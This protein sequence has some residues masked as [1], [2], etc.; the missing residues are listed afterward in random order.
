MSIRELDEFLYLC[1]KAWFKTI[2]EVHEYMKK[3]G[4]N[5][6]RI[7]HE[8]D[9]LFF[10]RIHKQEIYIRYIINSK[11]WLYSLLSIEIMSIIGFMNYLERFLYDNSKTDSKRQLGV[12]NL[13]A[14]LHRN[15]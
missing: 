15:D 3:E 14:T 13:Y 12:K 10:P 8:L 9:A 5:F 11:S 6:R 4:I 7:F 2:G 1:R